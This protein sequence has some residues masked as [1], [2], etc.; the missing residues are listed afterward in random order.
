MADTLSAMSIGYKPL[1]DLL[2]LDYHT[3]YH[4]AAPHPVLE[5]AK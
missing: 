1:F 2:R 4:S 3:G 5:L